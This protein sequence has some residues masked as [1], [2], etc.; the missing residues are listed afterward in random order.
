MADETLP[1]GDEAGRQ[2]SRELDRT[3]A[4]LTIPQR[5]TLSIGGSFAVATHAYGPPSSVQATEFVFGA[6]VAFVV[7]I[8][9]AARPPRQPGPTKALTGYAR[10]NITP[11]A[12]ITA[13]GLLVHF[14]STRSVGF[15]LS[16]A[17]AAGGYA[18]AVTLFEMYLQR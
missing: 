18:L 7:L 3:L 1:E 16:G 9:F 12:V 2:F 5:Y 6:L 13:V 11:L 4:Q 15:A 17:L 10:F 8:V 14:I